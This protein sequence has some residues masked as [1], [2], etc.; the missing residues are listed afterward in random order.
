VLLFGYEN[1]KEWKVNHLFAR[2]I[3]GDL[4]GDQIAVNNGDK[5]LFH[6]RMYA[7]DGFG[8]KVNNFQ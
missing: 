6:G 5:P 2:V 3:E 7:F 4:V 1:E 8:N